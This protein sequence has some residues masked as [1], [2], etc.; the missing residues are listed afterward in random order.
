MRSI[1]TFEFG[2]VGVSIFCL[3][4]QRL[5]IT[6]RR[7]VFVC[8]RVVRGVVFVASDLL[9]PTGQLHAASG[10]CGASVRK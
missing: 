2:V 8:L 4:T 10:V 1:L 9:I 6:T 3:R 5:S 7:V